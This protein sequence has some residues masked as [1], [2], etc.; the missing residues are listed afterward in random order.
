MG[1]KS[2]ED[3]RYWIWRYKGNYI[4]ITQPFCIFVKTSKFPAPKLLKLDIVEKKLEFTG[5]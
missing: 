4:I 5:I 2:L 3:Y 1:L